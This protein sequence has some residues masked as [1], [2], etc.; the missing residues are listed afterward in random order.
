MKKIIISLALFGIVSLLIMYFSPNPVTI[1]KLHVISE[2]PDSI[3]NIKHYKD[4]CAM[5]G[6]F[7]FAF[8]AGKEDIKKIIQKN[9]LEKMDTMPDFAEQLIRHIDTHNISWW[10]T[11]DELKGL[12]IYGKIK[13]DSGAPR[14]KIIFVGMDNKVVYL[15]E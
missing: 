3:K 8:E 11:T 13:D 12:E 4:R 2:I 5:H 1:F 9:T 10:K 15:E 7:V 14:V 6:P